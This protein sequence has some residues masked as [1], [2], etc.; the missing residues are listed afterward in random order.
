M[1]ITPANKRSFD[2]AHDDRLKREPR[3]QHGGPPFTPL[4]L[5]RRVFDDPPS[6]LRRIGLDAA[7]APKLITRPCRLPNPSVLC[8][9]GHDRVRGILK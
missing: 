3:M 9:V 4:V 2:V 6:V 1:L 8:H 5:R 7:H